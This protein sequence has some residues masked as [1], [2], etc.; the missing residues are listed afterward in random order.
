MEIKRSKG[1]RDFGVIVDQ[2]LKLCKYTQQ[3]VKE[4]NN[5][6]GMVR[7]SHSCLDEIIYKYLF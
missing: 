5:I 1:E 7:R 2:N 6:M 3:E 4:A